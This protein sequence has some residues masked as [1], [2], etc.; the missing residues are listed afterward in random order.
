MLQLLIPRCNL[1][2]TQANHTQHSLRRDTLALALFDLDHTLI[3]GD[4]DHGWGIFL[5]SIGVLDAQEQE[6]KQDYYYQQYL[7]GKLEIQEFLDFQLYPL[8]Q[9]PM[10]QLQEWRAAYI[11]RDIR[12]MLESGK[13]EL[14]EQHA[15][16][17]DELVII[18]ATNDFVTRPIADLLGVSTLIATTLELRNGQYTGKTVGP[19]CFQDGKVTKLEQWL[20]DS[21][22]SF[23]EQYF[24]SDSINDLP[25]LEMVDHP[26][27]VTPDAQLR[28]LAEKRDWKIID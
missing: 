10:Q 20:A 17:G 12:P 22:K 26:I 8:S 28:T 13:P 18:T 9:Y 16:R 2:S 3:N 27:A 23:D 25:L 7:Q 24:Y 21:G 5:A 14:V 6:E 11:E 1:H 15:R 4:S 19:P